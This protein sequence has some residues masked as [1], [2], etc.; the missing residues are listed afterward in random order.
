MCR[1]VCRRYTGTCRSIETNKHSSLL[2]YH[3]YPIFI[4]NFAWLVCT[5]LLCQ[6]L[7]K[8]IFNTKYFF[9]EFILCTIKTLFFFLKHHSLEYYNSHHWVSDKVDVLQLL[10]PNTSL[11]RY[12]YVSMCRFEIV[13]ASV[14]T[15]GNSHKEKENRA[16]G[17]ARVSQLQNMFSLVLKVIRVCW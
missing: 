8:I 12:T 3:K 5:S 4:Y 16:F 14:C 17:P 10:L 2:A 11:R 6:V 1:C 15:V 9:C 7:V 13:N